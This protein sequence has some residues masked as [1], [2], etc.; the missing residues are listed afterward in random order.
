LSRLR[1]GGLNY[2]VIQQ[3]GFWCGPGCLNGDPR[4]SVGF[5]GGEEVLEVRVPLGVGFGQLIVTTQAHA[6]QGDEVGRVEGDD[7]VFGALSVQ[8]AKEPAGSR[9]ILH[10]GSGYATGVFCGGEPD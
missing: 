3:R 5:F 2:R 7:G 1:T 4:I 9:S 8:G 6:A 10:E